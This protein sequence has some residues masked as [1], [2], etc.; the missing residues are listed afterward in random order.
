M[1]Q[2]THRADFKVFYPITT[3]WMDND[4]YGHVNNVTYYSY[5]DSAINRYLIDEG[6]LNIHSAPVVGFMVSSNCQYFK[7]IAYPETIEAGLRVKKIGTKSVTYEVAIF[8]ENEEE[9]AAI[10]EM[11]HVF[12][13][14]AS[15]TSVPVPDPIRNALGIIVS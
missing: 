6:G 1:S 10:G 5:F 2:N 15:N 8:R 9:A 11:V 4:I 13:E 12:V 3:R 14:R 7:P